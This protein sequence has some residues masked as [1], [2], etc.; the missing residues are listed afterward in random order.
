MVVAE[1]LI[2]LEAEVHGVLLPDQLVTN[3]T[4]AP[5]LDD[6]LGSRIPDDF[7]DAFIRDSC[8]TGNEKGVIDN[9]T[10]L[11]LIVVI[12]QPICSLTI[13]NNQID[14]GSKSYV[15]LFLLIYC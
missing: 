9:S 13:E 11:T 2:E 4:V 7:L 5:V 10:N 3:V 8:S 12:L 1:L 6:Q 15:T 14:V